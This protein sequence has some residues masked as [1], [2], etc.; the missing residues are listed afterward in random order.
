[1]NTLR[2]A[3]L[4]LLTLGTICQGA[5]TNSFAL[6][7]IAEPVDRRI[8]TN[9]KGDWSGLRLSAS[10]LISG[11][12]IV[13][14]DLT[15]HMMRLRAETL[16]RIPRPPVEGMPFVVVVNGER[17]Y[18]GAFTT[19]LSSMSVAVPSILVDRQMM[20][21]DHPT[22]TLVIDR[23]Y[24]SPSFGVG[25]DPRNDERVKSALAAMNKLEVGE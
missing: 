15:R 12:D 3:F 1:M 18:L 20:V 6:H 14:Y 9:G 22:N 24:P 7:L 21:S 10:P 16:S 13:S 2:T 23:A 19:C 11:E 25:P 4:G 17:I 5:T 8:I